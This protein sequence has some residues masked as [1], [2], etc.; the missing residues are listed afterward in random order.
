MECLFN[1][2]NISNYQE[3]FGEILSFNRDSSLWDIIKPKGS[4]SPKEVQNESIYYR[5]VPALL[6][7]N[8]AWGEAYEGVYPKLDDRAIKILKKRIKSWSALL[9]NEREAVLYKPQEMKEI[10]TVANKIFKVNKTTLLIRNKLS[11]MEIENKKL[12]KALDRF[13]VIIDRILTTI[14]IQVTKST[15]PMSEKIEPMFERIPALWNFQG[16][17]HTQYAAELNRILLPQTR[18]NP[19]TCLRIP[20]LLEPMHKSSIKLSQ[21]EADELNCEAREKN[22]LQSRERISQKFSNLTK[23]ENPL[24]QQQL[25]D[26]F[27]NLTCIEEIRICTPTLNIEQIM[28][29]LNH[30]FIEEN[31]AWKLSYFLGSLTFI[32]IEK[33]LLRVLA[34]SDLLQ[35]LNEIL[36]KIDDPAREWLDKIF[37]TLSADFVLITNRKKDEID[38]L[39]RQFRFRLENEPDKITWN[40]ILAIGTLAENINKHWQALK[41]LRILINRVLPDP[42]TN[43]V[44]CELDKEYQLLLKR[45]S[46]EG[47][48][49]ETDGSCSVN[50]SVKNISKSPIPEQISAGVETHISLMIS[51]FL[52]G[53]PSLGEQ[54]K[55]TISMHIL[56]SAADNDSLQVMA[57]L[58]NECM[59]I[60]AR[61]IQEAAHLN[62]ANGYTYGIIHRKVFEKRDCDDDMDASD[63]LGWWGINTPIDHRDAGLVPNIPQKEFLEWQAYM[64]LREGNA[65]S[66][67]PEPGTLTWSDYLLQLASNK[68]LKVKSVILPPRNELDALEHFPGK[69]YKTTHENLQRLGIKKIRDWKPRRMLDGNEEKSEHPFA[70]D[71]RGGIYNRSMMV[72][73]IFAPN[74]QQRL[75]EMPVAVLKE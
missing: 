12:R 14:P 31:N 45:L 21:S 46:D 24:W 15:Q 66:N 28:H 64:K 52:K 42:E 60:I 67:K 49:L 26:A 38:E 13:D 63:I 10:Q 22:L 35:A 37:C 30:C 43:H 3:R 58:D 47:P 4:E 29:I 36:R 57:R 9:E 20:S 16:P 59:G 75:S 70:L 55:G 68:D 1:N 17:A 40:D 33:A 34:Q 19:L 71:W 23:Q 50:F 56:K 48:H 7:K 69:V 5:W 53:S 27:N 44:L 51:R 72:E 54:S 74:I 32:K 65:F 18:L 11:D 8:Y 41:N 73:C 39:N 6:G 62:E 25:S 2:P 61:L